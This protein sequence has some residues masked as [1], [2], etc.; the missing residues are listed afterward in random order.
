MSK[1]CI[2]ILLTLLTLN[3]I[4]QT[5]VNWE[6][7]TVTVNGK[8]YTVAPITEILPNGKATRIEFLNNDTI[9]LSAVFYCTKNPQRIKKFK[10]RYE[11]WQNGKWKKPRLKIDTHSWNRFRI[12]RSHTWMRQTR[13]IPFWQ[14]PPR[15]EPVTVWSQCMENLHN[16]E[17]NIDTRIQLD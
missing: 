7:K 10:V 4:G 14:Y 16:Q 13:G 12:N 15:T 5:S 17:L 8:N 11:V 6:F 1:T 3:S 2:A 9:K